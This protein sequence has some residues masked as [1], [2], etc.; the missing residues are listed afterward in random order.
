MAQ[1]SRSVGPLPVHA[2]PRDLGGRWTPQDV[3]LITAALA[4]VAVVLILAMLRPVGSGGAA[5][6]IPWVLLA[7]LF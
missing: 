6:T 7:A 3:W 5:S 4:G 1:M 2:R